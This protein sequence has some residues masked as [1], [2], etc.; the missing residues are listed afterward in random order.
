MRFLTHVEAP[1]IFYE[2][3]SSD[4]LN[5]CILSDIMD[6][7]VL[8]YTGTVHFDADEEILKE[9]EAPEYLF[10]L[11]S[12]RAKLYLTHENGRVTLIN[13]LSAPCFIGEMELLDE[14]RHANGVRAITSCE[15]YAIDLSKCRSMLLKDTKFLRYLC[16]FL[17]DKATGNTNNYSRN[18]SYPLKNR[19]A[20]F[21]LE[22]SVNGYYREPHTEVADYLGVTYRHLLYVLAEFVKEGMLQKTESGYRIEDSEGLRKLIRE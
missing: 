2:R 21:I 8:P 11:Y 15:C 19:L 1:M 4:E 5:P 9:D 16:R 20:A 10:F 7:D 6:A 22:T 17:S 3:N 14:N 18:Q 12:G 13:F